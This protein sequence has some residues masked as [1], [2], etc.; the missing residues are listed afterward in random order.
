METGGD[1]WWADGDGQRGS[2]RKA[3]VG[4]E[5]SR[6]TRDGARCGLHLLRGTEERLGVDFIS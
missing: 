5:E 2:V 1:P 4:G 3:K 6:D